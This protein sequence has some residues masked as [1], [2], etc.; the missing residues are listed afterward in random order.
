VK[1]LALAVVC[2]LSLGGCMNITIGPEGNDPATNELRCTPIGG[3]ASGM[4]VLLAQSVPSA[5]EVP[6][7]RAVPMRW[8]LGVFDVRDGRA[9]VELHYVPQG[10]HRLVIEL[11]ASC[12]TGGATEYTSDFPGMRRYESGT[13]GAS[14][15]RYYVYPGG[16][17]ALRFNLPGPGAAELGADV[18]S[19]VGFVSRAEIDR[20]VRELSRGK[21]H[22]DPDDQR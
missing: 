19:A 13:G 18:G 21:L 5:S 16:C 10:D 6:C 20:R 8:V 15:Q 3:D 2:A 11:T 4:L 14:P 22:L 12:D 9:H 7:L 1:R 17:T